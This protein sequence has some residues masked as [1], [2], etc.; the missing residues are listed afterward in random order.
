MKEYEKILLNHLG[1]KAD[2]KQQL[3]PNIRTVMGD[4]AHTPGNPLTKTEI[5]LNIQCFSFAAPGFQI[6]TIPIWLFGLTD[7]YSGYIKA[8][9]ITP[10]FPYIFYANAPNFILNFGIVG[11]DVSIELA[12]GFAGAPFR[13]NNGDLFM[14]LLNYDYATVGI[15]FFADVRVSCQNVAYGTFLNSFVSDLITVST[16][17]FIVPIANIIQYVNPINFI[18]Q[19]LLGKTA[20]DSVNP[21]LYITNTDFQQQICDIPINLPID[22]NL[23]MT[24]GLNPAVTQMSIVMFVQKIEALTHK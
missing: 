21:R 22:K 18:Y 14:G 20:M 2:N 5:T 19:T 13:F 12:N 8:S 7:Y 23:I 15:Q 9:V 6:P 4:I 24:V 10:I 17:R 1:D 16:M 3:L 11:K